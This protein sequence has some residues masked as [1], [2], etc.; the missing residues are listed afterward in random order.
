MSDIHSGH[1]ALLDK[2]GDEIVRSLRPYRENDLPA[3]VALTNAADEAHKLQDGTSEEQIRIINESPRSEPAR[4][5]V[6]VDGPRMEGVPAGMLL[7]SGRVSYEEDEDN[8]ERIYYLSLVVHPAVEGRGLE[9]AIAAR[10]MEIVQGYE[11]DPTMRV[12]ERAWVKAYIRE[13]LHHLRDL[14]ESMGLR[15]VR[16]FWAMARPLHEPIDEPGPVEGAEIRQYKLPDDNVAANL[17][18]NDSFSDHWDHH[19]LPQDDWDYWMGVPNTRPDLSWLA[20]VEG[21]AGKIA[22]FCIIAISEESNKLR[23]VCE[24]WVELLGTTGDWRRKGLGRA[25]LL[26]G[27]HSLKSAGM[28]TAMLGVDSTSLTGA[29]RL[30]ESVGFRIRNRTLQ[31]E[32]LLSAVA[33]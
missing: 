4:Q 6:V 11:S 20:E 5:V 29:N 25:L 19:Q 24:G 23:D 22:G 14:C 21:D 26:H 18:F 9:R 1:S 33:L 3:L 2:S 13:E 16:Q 10:L 28:D 31:Y 30:Y 32:S 27:L 7:G 8:K 17:A 15:P 12:M